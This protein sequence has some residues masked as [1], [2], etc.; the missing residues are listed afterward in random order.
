MD[1]YAGYGGTRFEFDPRRQ[2]VWNEVIGY[3]EELL[4]KPSSI[5]DMGAGYCAAVN[6]SS[7][8]RKY[9]CDIRPEFASHATPGVKTRVCSCENLSWLPEGESLDWVI[10]SNLFE[11]LTRQ[12]VV[13]CL[14]AV[15]ER[16]HRLGSLIVIQPNFR[17]CY[18]SYFDDY[19]HL[20][21]SIFTEISMAD[22]LRT[23]G[24]E[25]TIVRRGFLPFS[26]KGKL[27]IHR[28]L[29][30]AYLRSPFKPWSG[31][32]LIVAKPAAGA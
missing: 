12:T 6:A 13:R 23:Q 22:Y 32:M 26:M 5:L 1:G 7:A 18:R 8:K 30:A 28:L 14:S 25:P 4:G 21:E 19:T 17:L 9:A 24:F 20:P 27:P 3:L 31:Q 11:H 16:L 15:R 2:M 29:V 10:A